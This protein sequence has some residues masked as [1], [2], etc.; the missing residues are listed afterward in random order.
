[1][2][3][4]YTYDYRHYYEILYNEIIKYKVYNINLTK[5]HIYLFILVGK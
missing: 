5:Y 4:K 1:M 3:S 2:N